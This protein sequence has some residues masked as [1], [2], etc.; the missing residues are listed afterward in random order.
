MLESE[1]GS[2]NLAIVIKYD[3]TDKLLSTDTIVLTADTLNLNFD[4]CFDLIIK[5]K[6]RCS[7]TATGFLPGTTS[8]NKVLEGSYPGIDRG[9]NSV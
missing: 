3:I 4:K 1:S 6:H 8:I 9:D 7:L 5:V 2:T